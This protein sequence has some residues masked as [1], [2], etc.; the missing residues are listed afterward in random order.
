M[1]VLSK[2]DADYVIEQYQGHHIYLPIY[3]ALMTGMRLGEIAALRWQNVNLEQCTISVTHSLQMQDNVLVLKEPKTK[4]SRRN[5]PLPSGAVA[6]L[7]AEYAKQKD[8]QN[9]F[10]EAYDNR[11]F[12][13]AWE[14]G[15]PYDPEWIGKR[16]AKIVEDDV[17]IPDRVRFHDLRHTHAT[18]LMSQDIN[19]KVIQERLGHGSIATTG[20]IYCHVAPGMQTKAVELLEELF[21]NKETQP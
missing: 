5:I 7:K 12:V 6:L 19:M 16:W 17:N 10:D 18:I 1:T 20:D 11:G 3:L 13:C 14:D 2:Q 8:Y 9:Y 15:M 4:T 21:P